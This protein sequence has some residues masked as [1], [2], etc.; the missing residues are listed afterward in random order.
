[1]KQNTA[2]RSTTTATRSVG[3]GIATTLLFL[4]HACATHPTPRLVAIAGSCALAECVLSFSNEAPVSDN[5][6]RLLRLVLL[7]AVTGLYPS[8]RDTLS[9]GLLSKPP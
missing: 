3:L 1:M 5:L 2:R 6:P 4:N 9:L 7:L 8:Y